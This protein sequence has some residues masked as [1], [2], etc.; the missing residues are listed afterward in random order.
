[1][2]FKPGPSSLTLDDL[3]S[4]DFR[5]ATNH[6][7]N[8]WSTGTVT[9]LSRPRRTLKPKIQ[10]TTSINFNEDRG[11]DH[12]EVLTQSFTRMKLDGSSS[13]GNRR[14]RYSEPAAT[15]KQEPS[16]SIPRRTKRTPRASEPPQTIEISHSGAVE[17]QSQVLSDPLS[18]IRPMLSTEVVPGL[19]KLCRDSYM[20]QTPDAKMLSGLRLPE[21]YTLSPHQS[22]GI[23]WMLGRE[24][25]EADKH[26]GINAD[27]M[28]L[29]K[30]L[31]TLA[32]VMLD[33]DKHVGPS[34]V[35]VQ[36]CTL[37]SQWK[38]EIDKFF[39]GTKVKVYHGSARFGDLREMRRHDIVITTF[40]CVRSEHAT[41]ANAPGQNKVTDLYTL[42]RFLKFKPYSDYSWFKPNI[43][44]PLKPPKSTNRTQ[45]DPA[46][47]AQ[48][49]L[50]LAGLSEVLIRR[51]KND[52][53]NG[54]KD[55]W[56]SLPISSTF[57]LC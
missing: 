34:L 7:L 5:P 54:A 18:D 20:Q 44:V 38:D 33:P 17:E 27:E 25:I 40:G 46:E 47:D 56:I 6:A 29:G 10:E 39:P 31:Q 57:T 23:L 50:K 13:S 48:S 11:T 30:T 36:N 1:M 9:G 42:F 4:F 53:I 15:T 21:G 12:S 49:A 43:E 2:S 16:S 35:V 26:G 51:R 19:E 8:D 3:S 32:L 55:L 28:G 41:F 24:N 22:A 52:Y 45:W 37:A 14:P